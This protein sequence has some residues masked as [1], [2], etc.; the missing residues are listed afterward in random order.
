MYQA[1]S[2]RE[3]HARLTWM[4]MVL[5]RSFVA[6]ADAG[7]ITKA[8]EELHVSQ[9]ALSR[10][11]QQLEAE[12]GADLL[13]R[14]RQGIELT[15]VGRHS[16]IEGRSIVAAYE[17]LQRNVIE[18]LGLERGEVRIGAG[19]T[20][21]TFVLPRAIAT[22]QTRY[23]GVRF[24]VR[25]AG[26]RDIASHVATGELDLG[27]VTLAQPPK[28]LDLTP[29]LHDDIV[30]AAR[31]DH[32]ITQ[33]GVVR[34]A[35]LARQPFVAFE[36]ASAIREII[37]SALRLADVTLD[38]VMELRSIPSMLRMVSSTGCL[39]FV[40]RLSLT[41]EQELRAIT[42]RDLAISRTIA[43]ATRRD[44]PLSAPAA[45]FAEHLH[46]P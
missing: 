30:L 25:E 26:S 42:V 20:M 35:D 46:G 43:L 45:A 34:P 23:P 31:S 13:V 16:L 33:L 14:G 4:D 9:S 28:D 7:T 21:A 27:L 24:Y 5:L 1:H 6:V 37:D 12:L 44:I 36:P 3:Y 15:A 40:S 19:A 41:D 18:H 10:R 2:L 8:A 29:V 17:R 11:L 39:A 38:I 32:P 22:F